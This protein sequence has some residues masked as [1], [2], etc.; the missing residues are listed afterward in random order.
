MFC[1][2]VFVK[3]EYNDDREDYYPVWRRNGQQEI[4]YLR[5]EIDLAHS[6]FPITEV[7]L[8]FT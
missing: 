1:F 5:A 3:P 8:S 2:Q 4:A 7:D 6:N